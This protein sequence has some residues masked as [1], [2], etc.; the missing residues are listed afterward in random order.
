MIARS[1]VRRSSPYH[2]FGFRWGSKMVSAWS[3]RGDTSDCENEVESLLDVLHPAESDYISK[4]GSKWARRSIK[5]RC[6]V[7]AAQLCAVTDS[8]LTGN[9]AFHLAFDTIYPSSFVLPS[10]A[11]ISDLVR[12]AFIRQQSDGD[13]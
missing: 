1:N 9:A 3:Q 13:G 11:D 8:F 2:L 5:S 10:V 7:R 12:W 4:A 6:H